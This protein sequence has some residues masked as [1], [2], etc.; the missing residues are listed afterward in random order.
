MTDGSMLVGEGGGEGGGDREPTSR[1]GGK[2]MGGERKEAGSCRITKVVETGRKRE[3]SYGIALCKKKKK[4]K[5][6]GGNQ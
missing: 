3:K 4:K 5:K 6:T 2:F 1:G